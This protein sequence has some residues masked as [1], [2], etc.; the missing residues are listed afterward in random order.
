M[1]RI[2][3]FDHFKVGNDLDIASWDSYPLGFLEDCVGASEQEQ[4]D[5]SVSAI[6]IFRLF[7]TIYISPLARGAGG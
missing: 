3:D 7:I 1:G 6:L 2:T 5:F 4:T